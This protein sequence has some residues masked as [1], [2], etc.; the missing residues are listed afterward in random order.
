MIHRGFWYFII[1]VI[2]VILY[3]N[4][5]AEYKRSEDLEIYEMD[6]KNNA[7]LQ[8]ICAVKQPT[9]FDI[10][11]FCPELFSAIMPGL[12]RHETNDLVIKDTTLVH[13]P[14]DTA[15]VLPLRSAS[16]LMQTDTREQYYSEDNEGFLFDTGAHGQIRESIDP[17]LKPPLTFLGHYD[18]LLGSNKAHTPL[19]Y[20]TASR[21]FYVV[22]QG[23]IRVKMAPYSF[24]KY[25]SEPP[26]VDN[27]FFGY[28][29][30]ENVWTNTAKPGV[31]EFIVSSG[32][33]LYV[34]PYWWFSI[35]FMT[36]DK[37]ET[38]LLSCRYYTVPNIIANGQ[39]WGD[40]LWGIWTA[41]PKVVRTLEDVVSVPADK[42]TYAELPPPPPAAVEQPIDSIL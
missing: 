6:Y 27:D 19:R 22:T 16:I 36:S 34:P 26:R 15:V 23:K 9:I 35:Q 18:W 41:K 30:S 42:D 40:Y 21:Q 1:A 8:D 5:A 17:L 12:S 28:I 29:S 39:T 32:S 25:L 33:V 3:S 10:G 14:V 13:N 2:L 24:V 31:Q 11:R 20:H 7:Q 38:S 4:V 37:V